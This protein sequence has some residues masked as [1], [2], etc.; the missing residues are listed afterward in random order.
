[1]TITLSQISKRGKLVPGK[2]VSQYLNLLPCIFH[3]KEMD[4]F[5]FVKGLGSIGVVF[6]GKVPEEVR[7]DFASHS[8]EIAGKSFAIVKY[9]L[10]DSEKAMKSLSSKLVSDLSTLSSFVLMEH[11]AKWEEYKGKYWLDN[12]APPRLTPH[13]NIFLPQGS[14]GMY[15]GYGKDKHGFYEKERRGLDFIKKIKIKHYPKIT[16][17]YYG[18]FL[19]VGNLKGLPSKK[20]TGL[21]HF[22]MGVYGY[23]GKAVVFHVKSETIV[24][25]QTI[26]DTKDCQ[27]ICS[28]ELLAKAFKNT[29]Y[30][31]GKLKLFPSGAVF[32]YILDGNKHSKDTL[33]LRTIVGL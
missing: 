32:E 1:M 8:V 7:P 33:F 5:I 16:S 18:K 31:N 2:V 10:V 15:F 12:C 25:R 22:T 14:I 11:T 9:S 4:N 24:G 30:K 21:R 28:S 23:K 3:K 20:E 17:Y 19:D 13:G 26:L 27:I 29:L 6:E